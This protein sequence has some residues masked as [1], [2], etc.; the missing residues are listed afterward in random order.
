[1]KK[2]YIKSN[3][4]YW[5]AKKLN[6]YSMR[7][8][9]SIAILMGIVVAWAVINNIVNSGDLVSPAVK[10]SFTVKQLE[11]KE[12]VTV[13]C[14]S[15]KGFLECQVYQGK[16][17]WEDHDKLSQIIKCESGWNP[18]ALNKNTNGTFD[19]GLFQINTVHKVSRL[20]ML[21]YK[22]NIEYGIKLYKKQGVTPWVC[23]RKL[24]IK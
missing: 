9:Y 23:A 11:A 16:I 17:T 3:F 13:S 7:I 5:T 14:E 10:E 15:P 22:K 4:K 1:M 18:E 21:D 8:W 2:Q 20:E 6:K 12:E 19:L 24:N